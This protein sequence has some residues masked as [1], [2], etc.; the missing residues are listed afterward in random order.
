MYAKK[1]RIHTSLF[2]P[3]LILRILFLH[4]IIHSFFLLLFHE[5]TFVI[6]SKYN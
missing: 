1:L 6:Y 3:K 4:F 5:Q 2:G